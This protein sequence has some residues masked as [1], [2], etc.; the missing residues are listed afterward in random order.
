MTNNSQLSKL[1]AVDK[2]LAAKQA[3]SLTKEFGQAVVTHA[4]RAAVDRARAQVRIETANYELPTTT[5]EQKTANL[6]RQGYEG[7][8]VTKGRKL[9]AADDAETMEKAAIPS[10]LKIPDVASI[11][12]D[13]EIIVR[14]M[15]CPAL[16][17]VIN[18]TGVILHTNLGR[19]P[20]GHNVMDEIA[21]TVTG[22]SDLEFDLAGGRRGNRNTLVKELLRFLTGAEDVLVVNNNAAGILLALN[23]LAKDREVVISRGE[24]VEI[25]AS[26][27]IPEIMQAGGVQMVEVGTTNRTHLSDY[28]DA[29]NDN[30]ALLFKAHKSNYSIQGFAESVSASDIARVA[31]KHDLPM[32]YDIGSG[33]LKSFKDVEDRS[34]S[35][36]TVVDR[37]KSLKEEPGV[38]DALA[39]G[40]DIVAFSCDKLLGGPQAGI[41]AG[42]ADL[43]DRM[44]HAP[45][46]RALRV[47]KLTLAALS[48]VCRQY[49]K[50]E[51]LLANNPTF[52]MLCRSQ[53][54][55]RALARSLVKELNSRGIKG[56]IVASSGQ[57]GGGS[58]PESV[59]ESLAVELLPQANIGTAKQT[60]AET[61]HKRL[62]ECERPVLGILREG[63]L[64][65]DMLTVF[66]NEVPLIAEGVAAAMSRCKAE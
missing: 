34:K 45:L 53:K 61:V 51:D 66:K 4:V 32:I 28:Q 50:E 42:R 26:F 37:L 55:L 2:V 64:L 21:A 47:D 58:M 54:E 43:I 39:S 3:K 18:T 8:E 19:A 7:R 46:M 49:L 60:F 23:T 44:A 24:L 56:Q 5:S 62:L 30:T 52:A 59:L 57:C 9:L 14:R 33:V 40:A 63:R 48:S 17:P 11:V 31:H 10:S 22:Y 25:G 29:M 41:L 15:C 12:A 1:P 6:L 16:N 27:R 65:F 38:I 20:L 35:F 13:A 36:N